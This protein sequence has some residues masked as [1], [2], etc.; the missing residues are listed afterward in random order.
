[1]EIPFTDAE[2]GCPTIKTNLSFLP[3]S[4]KINTVKNPSQCE[5]SSGM[6]LLSTIAGMDASGQ[7]WAVEAAHAAPSELLSWAGSSRA[8][9]VRWGPAIRN[10]PSTQGIHAGAM[11]H[12]GSSTSPDPVSTGTSAE[13]PHLAMPLSCAWRCW[14]AVLKTRGQ[15]WTEIN[16]WK[17]LRLRLLWKI[18]L[19][20]TSTMYIHPH[21]PLKIVSVQ[22]DISLGIYSHSV[23]VC[24][25]I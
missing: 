2:G 23:C 17:S 16:D 9:W 21:M 1:M 8:L 15:M 19:E 14:G 12:G 3:S 4:P 20:G 24:M 25:Y 7:G 11:L 10:S 5:L 22:W 6:P 18:W 13:A